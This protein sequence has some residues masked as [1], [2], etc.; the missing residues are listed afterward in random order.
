MYRKDEK[1]ETMDA[2]VKTHPVSVLARGA[3][4]FPQRRKISHA[5][6]NANDMCPV[7]FRCVRDLVNLS[8]TFTATR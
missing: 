8:T 2:R 1:P 6:K 7:T 5:A 3:S 4:M